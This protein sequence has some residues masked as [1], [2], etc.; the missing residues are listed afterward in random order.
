MHRLSELHPE[1]SEFLE[2]KDYTDHKNARSDKSLR[3]VV[4]EMFTYCPAW[5]RG[6]YRIR[7][8][9]A[10]L[11]G[12]RHDQELS[13]GD[14]SPEAISMSPGGKV[15]FFNV[16]SAR[17]NTW[18]VGEINDAHLSAWVVV[19]R[20]PS[21]AGP[22]LFHVATSVRHRHWIGPLYFNLIR[23]FHHFI[24]ASMLRRAVRAA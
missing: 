6:F 3:A 13:A 22:A 17:E 21:A 24:V 1:L 12:L 9:L 19:V 23:P 16:V 7:G 8:L 11:L 10:R 18:W 15:R 5:L 2:N 14:V 20:E 4:T